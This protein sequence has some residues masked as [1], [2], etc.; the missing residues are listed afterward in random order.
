MYMSTE[1]AQRVTI[2]RGP[3]P[4]KV[5]AASQYMCRRVISEAHK[6]Q[7]QDKHL[8]VSCRLWVRKCLDDVIDC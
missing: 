1:S 4:D 8:V 5:K 3:K 7:L 2:I 6:L